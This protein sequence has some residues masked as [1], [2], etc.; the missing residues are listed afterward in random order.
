[1]TTGVLDREMFAE[2]E[3]ARLL[4]VSQSTLHWWLDGGT[5]RGRTYRPVIRIEPRG[6]RSVTWA[7]FVE[8]GLL[9]E[10]RRTHKIALAQLRTV[11]DRLR[12]RYGVPYPLA[13]YQ[14]FVGPGRELLLA[15]Q[16]EAALDAE[17]CL[18]AV[19]NDQLLLTPAVET[20][21]QR[22]QWADDIA[23]GWRPHDDPASPIRMAPDVRFGRPAIHGVSTAVLWEQ[24]EG[25]GSVEE[26]A[27]TFDLRPGDVRWAYGYESAVRVA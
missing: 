26:V 16:Q 25:G 5:Y 18:V 14:P 4:R 21:V 13:H 3:A 20:F 11:I 8:A 1:M 15:V 27:E 24:L 6:E 10:Y 7:E 12:E 19:A 22:V 17:V 9:R 23:V 2:A